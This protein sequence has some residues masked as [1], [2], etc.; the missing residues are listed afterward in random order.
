MNEPHLLDAFREKTG[1]MP[2]TRYWSAGG[3]PKYVNAL[4]LEE[5]PYLLQ[6][7]HNPVDWLPWNES[8][9]E[10]ARAEDRPIFLS[11]GYSTCHWCQV[12]GRES[13]EDEEI[14]EVLNTLFI[15]IKVDRE[16]LPDVDAVYMDFLQ[17]TTGEGGWPM[18]LF[19]TPEKRPLFAST[20]LPPRD[21]DRGVKVGLITYLKVMSNSWSDPRLVAQ[22][23]AP[24]RVLRDY[25][26]QPPVTQLNSDWLAEAAQT[27]MDASSPYSMI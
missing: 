13:F 7:A 12:M 17:I 23:E 4:I 9:F 20:Y 3:Q 8:T 2:R 25:A 10:R 11:I 14:A 21:G 5:S 18:N 24:L 27:W 26:I 22:G 19:L 16:E 6:H 1:H 15:P